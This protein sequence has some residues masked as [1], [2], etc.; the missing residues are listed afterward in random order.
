[1]KKVFLALFI[2]IIGNPGKAQDNDTAIYK[3]PIYTASLIDVIKYLRDN[4][5]YSD[6][7][8]GNK[9]QV[10]ISAVIEKDGK[11]VNVEVKKSSGIEKLDKEAVRL[12]QNA[13]YKPASNDRE[14]PVR[15]NWVIFIDFPP[16]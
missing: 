14:N 7:N 15:S 9:K 8:K 4:N 3:Y 11:A 10:L 13:K 5:K 12:I 1:M 6:W 2:I 16:I